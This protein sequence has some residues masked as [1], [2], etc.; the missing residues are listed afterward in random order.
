MTL[1]Y[2]GEV[3]YVLVATTR[4]GYVVRVEFASAATRAEAIEAAAKV[5]DDFSRHLTTPVIRQGLERNQRIFKIP[6]F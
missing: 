4:N 1:E 5:G 3:P 2:T 6:A